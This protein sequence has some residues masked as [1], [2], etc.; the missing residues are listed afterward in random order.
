MTPAEWPEVAALAR[1]TLTPQSVGADS[2]LTESQLHPSGTPTKFC[3]CCK[4]GTFKHQVGAGL[5]EPCPEDSDASAGSATCLFGGGFIGSFYENPDNVNLPLPSPTLECISSVS[6]GSD[7]VNEYAPIYLDDHYD[8]DLYDL[9]GAKVC[10]SLFF[11]GG[12]R[13]LGMEL[14]SEFGST[15]L[16]EKKSRRHRRGHHQARRGVLVGRK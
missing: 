13:N 11:A 14:K 15:I 16:W 5:C 3:A 8:R 6:S 10:M 2:S 7:T 12:V 1:V 9:R 4:E